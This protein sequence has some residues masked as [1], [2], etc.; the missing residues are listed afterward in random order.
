MAVTLKM[1]EE[2][3]FGIVPNGFNPEEVDNFLDDIWEELDRLLRENRDLQQKLAAAAAA[4]APVV[5]AVQPAKAAEPANSASADDVMEIL[6]MAQ[7]IKRDMIAKAQAEAAELMAIAEQ[8]AN[9]KLG[10]LNAEK[11]Q[12]EAQVASLKQ[13]AADYRAKFEALLAAQQDAIDKATDLF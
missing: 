8:E 2:K 9:D 12:L 1:I 5:P 11:E 7:Q 13:A 10:N 4:P 3:E 6:T